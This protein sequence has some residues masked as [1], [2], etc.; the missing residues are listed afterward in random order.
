MIEKV[1]AYMEQHHMVHSG[2][3]ISVGVSGGADSVCLFLI[4][5]H[6]R[7]RM[8]FS[9]SVVHIEHG[10]RGE[11]S[12]RDMHFVERL[13]ALHNVPVTCLS[14]PV[15]QIAKE[16]GL[17]VEEAG[18]KVRYE[19]FEREESRFLAEASARGGSVKTALAHHCDDNA[20]TIVFHMCRGS[21]IEGLVGIRPVR[22]NIIRPLLCVT[23]R[24][25]EEFL[26]AQGQEY[27]IDATNA[28]VVYSRNRI[29]NCI[30]PQLSKV[31]EQAVLHMSYLSQDVQELSTYLNEQ[32]DRILKE[33]LKKTEAGSV[34]FSVEG[35]NQY[36]PVIQRR[37]MLEVIAAVSGSRKDITR[38]HANTLLGIAKGQVGRKISLPYGL[39]AE[40][41][42]N[43]LM[44]Y[45]QKAKQKDLCSKQNYP[46]FSSE[47]PSLNAEGE[48]L[49]DKGRF[50][51][52]IFDNTK[53][54]TEIPKNQCTKWFDCDKIKN[55]LC[56]RTRE[57]GDYFCLDDKGHRQK[58]KDYWINEKVPKSVRDETL[59]LADGSHVMW[60]IGKRISTHY[61]IT[62]NTRKILEVQFVE[63]LT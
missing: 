20:E 6:L 37:V 48:I 21:G 3:H 4:L 29:R 36:P 18:R 58:L 55:R 42:Y 22:G 49:T 11:E 10:I 1:A 40:K 52:R 43:T 15:E 35:L 63:E 26:A 7:E 61:K 8:D 30:M 14:Y 13:C 39:M 16:Q 62:D 45:S 33:Y 38:E 57:P 60:V 19:A 53:K 32:V 31:N 56:L 46:L 12:L 44:V 34:A 24:E 5:V 41:T 47:I 54:D 27:C 28:D 51:Y 2:D 25:I 23:R 9:V 17:S 50:C 59:L